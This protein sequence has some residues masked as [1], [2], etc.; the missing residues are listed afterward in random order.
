[1]IKNGMIW[2]VWVMNM[3]REEVKW[4]RGVGRRCNH[5]RQS[6][7]IRTQ[8]PIRCLRM[9]L[10]E[11]QTGRKSPIKGEVVETTESGVSTY[12]CT[13]M[14]ISMKFMLGMGES[15]HYERV[16]PARKVFLQLQFLMKHSAD[17]VL[18]IPSVMRETIPYKGKQNLKK[19]RFLSRLHMRDQKVSRLERC[20][21]TLK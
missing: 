4:M 14:H 16:S 8:Q 13:Y 10:Q 3:G 18:D 17:Y 9:D 5:H 1:M 6:T 21:N 7:T 2:E 15:V 20:W 11:D 12:T 19:L